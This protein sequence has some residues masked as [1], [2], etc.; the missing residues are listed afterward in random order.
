MMY[1][2]STGKRS[3]GYMFDNTDCE[4]LERK[5]VGRSNESWVKV[6]VEAWVRESLLEP[7][8]QLGNPSVTKIYGKRARELIAGL[9]KSGH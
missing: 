8:Y 9:S 6:R 5:S 2:N 3:L 1:S 7:R 4:I